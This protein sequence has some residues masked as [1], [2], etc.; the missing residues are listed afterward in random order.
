MKKF[1]NL[2]I[3]GIQNKIFNLILFTVIL[4]TAA[5]IALSL[6][7]SRMLVSLTEESSAKQK[8][9]IGD[10]T[11]SVMNSVVE[12]SMVKSANM[13]AMLAD[14]MFSGLKTR[15]EMMGQY[16]EK[17]FASPDQYPRMPYAV[18]DPGK[19]GQVTAQ[20]I[21]AEDADLDNPV[22]TDHIGLAANMSDMMISLFGVSAETNSCFIALSEGAFLVVDDRSQ[23]KFDASGS[24]VHYDPRTRPWYLLAVEKQSLIFTDVEIDAFTGDIGI[25]CAMPVYVDGCLAAVVGS[26]L[27]LTSMKNGV[28]ASAADG[29]YV[30]IVNSQG[31]PVFSAAESGL[32]AVKQSSDAV[33]LREAHN[34]E[35]AELV[36]RAMHEETQ[37]RLVS[38][39]DGDYYMTG[40][41][42]KTVGWVLLNI[43]S[44]E[45]AEQPGIMLQNSFDSIQV[46]AIQSY[47]SKTGVAQK[48]AIA[49]LLG[50]TVLML[51]GALVRGK[52]IVRPLDTITKRIAELGGNNIEFKMEDAYRTGDEIELLAD[53]FASLSHKTVE[54]I[55]QVKTVTAE[56]ERIGTE[57]SM[58]T[59]IQASMLPHIFPA[60]PDRADFDIYASM[61]PAKEVGGDFYDYFLIDEDHL[62]MV[63]ADVSGK[64]V[65][66]ALFMMASKIILQSV[67]M[68]GHSPADILTKT[69]N[70]ICSNN[71]AEMFVT[72]WLGILELS[73]GHLRAANA[74]HEYPVVTAGPN[75]CFELF[76]DK[77][78]FVIGGMDGVRYREYEL[79]ITPGT[80]LFVY[81]DGVPEAT[82]AEN[83]LFGTD[84]MLEALNREPDTTPKQILA[85]VR[86]SVDAFVKDAEQ[87]DDLTMLC[88]QYNGKA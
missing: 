40:A 27:F 64:G 62:C 81:T 67:A 35:L 70:A 4:L 25:V 26:D 48:T 12:K 20:V 2:V 79:D 60:F 22:L 33:D 85:N 74:G 66:A 18:P 65:P 29:S 77:H 54:Y 53:S 8:T 34:P 75:S 51:A 73:T 10:I 19:S 11:G 87:F 83:E 32:F 56:K 61:D 5:F 78:G 80:R 43:L 3:G 76:K 7:Q 38:L 86:S 49:L 31:H 39:D 6:H 24:M 17:L 68:L 57:L 50:V 28:E 63:I 84:R 88:L 9:S 45:L 30:C 58:A 16:A 21:L 69:N 13:E 37:L 15:V 44:R 1:K 55:E 36:E 47:R 23:T 71:E 59:Q 41:P 72:V 52:R 82:N 42:M 46:E 14:E